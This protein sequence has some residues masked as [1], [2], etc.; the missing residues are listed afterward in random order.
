VEFRILGRLEVLEDGRPVVLAGAKQ[1]ELL[2]IL[3]LSA[4]EVVSRDRLIDGLWGTSPPETAKTA[5]QV[6]VSQ[7]RKVIGRDAIVTRAPGYMISVEEGGL[8]LERFERLVEAAR[9]EEPAAAAARL[10]EALALWRGPVLADID[11]PEFLDAERAR[12]DERRLAVIEQ[13]V[14]ADLELGRH[15]ELVSELERLVREHPLR[16]RLRGQL[17]LALYR[18]GR[19]AD[20]L[21]TYRAGRR[22]LDEELGLQPG[23]ELRHLERAILEQDPSLAHSPASVYRPDPAVPTG[24]VTF[25]FTDIEG[26]TRLVSELGDDY[27]ALLEQ[28]HAL[29]RAAFEKHGGEEIDTQGDAFFFAYRRARDSVRAAVEAQQALEAARWPRGAPVRVRIG[30]HTGEPG[31]TESGYHG[32]D[33]VRAARISGTAHGG[34]ILVSS[35]TRDLVGSAVTDVS[36]RDLGEHRL[37]DIEDP[38]RIFQVLAPGLADGFPPLRTADAARVMAISGREEE[39][40]AAA[41]AALGAEERRSRLFGRSRLAALV[42]ALVLAGAAAGL[43]LALRGGGSGTV[44]VVPNSVAV[45]DPARSRLAA[46][47]PVGQ[48]P[49]AVAAGAGGVWVANADDQTVSRIDPKRRKVVGTIGVGTDVTDIAVGYGSV[50]VADGNDGTVTQIDPKLNAQIRTIRFGSQDELTPNPVFSVTTGAGS[51]WVTRGNRLVRIDPRTGEPTGSFPIPPPVSIAAGDDAVWVA[52][53]DERLLRFD[54]R[55]GTQTASLSLPA[56]S[57]STVVGPEAVWMIVALGRGQIWRVDPDSA[58]AAGTTA[59]NRLPVDIALG[60]NAVWVAEL[61]GTVRRIDAGTGTSRMIRVGLAPQA[62][63]VDANGVWIALQRP[64]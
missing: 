9:G 33:V 57:L 64:T 4:G 8:D 40:A 15:A 36:F 56:S 20:A 12:L 7:L 53:Q 3:L 32:L 14:E 1:R 2:A 30:I 27:G 37:K 28:H 22:L 21:E 49:V 35:A 54:P 44:T 24:T 17:M 31:F 52:T 42:G 25:L 34:Q 23:E 6:H 50:W 10:R 18:C 11:A 48:R 5:L 16:E 26:S 39:L 58:T 60:E 38:Q 47:V 62:L 45:I 13:R 51:V 61:S 19:Q 41:E 46:D 59:S 63:A 55:S 43:V 29:V